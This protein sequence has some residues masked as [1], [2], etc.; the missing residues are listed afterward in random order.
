MGGEG[1]CEQQRG[2]SSRTQG[3]WV[4]L[5]SLCSISMECFESLDDN[6]AFYYK[7]NMVVL[8]EVGLPSQVARFS[9][10]SA[11]TLVLK[12]IYLVIITD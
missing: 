4:L 2:L 9:K 1:A 10:V 3:R 5:C 7:N 6:N 8:Q 11:Y 12:V